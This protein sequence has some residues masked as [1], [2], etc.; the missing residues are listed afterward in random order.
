MII[1]SEKVKDEYKDLMSKD[2]KDHDPVEPTISF[3]Y[4]WQHAY[5]RK[6]YNSANG[7]G[8]VVEQ[9]TRKIIGIIVFSKNCRYCELDRKKQYP[10][11][12][13]D[14]ISNIVEEQNQKFKQVEKWYV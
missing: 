6:K 11:E 9:H 7:H 8:F 2:C 13:N 1:V 3:D 5:S 14:D 10:G 12:T 4:G